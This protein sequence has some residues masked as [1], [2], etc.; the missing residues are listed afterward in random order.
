MK[1]NYVSILREIESDVRYKRHYLS[2][3]KTRYIYSRCM[4]QFESYSIYNRN[5]ELIAFKT[6]SILSSRSS[7][8]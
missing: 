5:K 1:T 7:A 8:F 4:K 3:I 6:D 2:L